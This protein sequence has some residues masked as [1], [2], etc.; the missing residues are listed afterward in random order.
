MKKHCLLRKWLNDGNYIFS[1]Q[2]IDD[3]KATKCDYSLQS[4]KVIATILYQMDKRYG[5]IIGGTQNVQTFSLKQ[6][7]NKFGNDGK[8][9][10]IKELRQLH[11]RNVFQPIKI[12][13]LSE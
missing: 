11:D 9:A 13:D 5:K 1:Q 7:I 10:A 12:Q 6:G 2:S 4:G 3:S 8:Q